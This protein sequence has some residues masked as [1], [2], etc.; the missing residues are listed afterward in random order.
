MINRGLLSL[1]R[2]LIAWFESGTEPIDGQDEDKYAN[3]E[4]DI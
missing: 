1:G 2:Y 4:A 3:N